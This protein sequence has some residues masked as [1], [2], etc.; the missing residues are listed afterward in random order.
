M[1]GPRPALSMKRLGQGCALVAVPVMLMAWVDVDSEIERMVVPVRAVVTA[2]L[3]IPHHSIDRTMDLPA[4]V[5]VTSCLEVNAVLVRPQTFVAFVA[6]ITIRS[7]PTGQ[8]HRKA[9][10]HR[11]R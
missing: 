1:N 3:A 4:F 5:A 10:S 7:R 2:P 9:K 6:P 8:R 11:A